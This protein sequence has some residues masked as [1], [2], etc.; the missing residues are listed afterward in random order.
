MKDKLKRKTVVTTWGYGDR[1]VILTKT[2]S[3]PGKYSFHAVEKI[4][5]WDS[6]GGYI[7]I[8]PKA[9]FITKFKNLIKR[10]ITAS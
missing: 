10:I 3:V 8:P 1:V 2:K 9:K 5:S 7:I 6:N 4:D